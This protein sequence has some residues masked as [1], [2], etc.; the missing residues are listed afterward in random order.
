MSRTLKELIDGTRELRTLPSTTIRLLDLLD[1]ATAGAEAVLEVVEKDPSLTAN[2]LKLCNSAYYGLRAQ[3]GT[4]H[5]ALVRLGNLT[6][7]NLAF[8]ASMGDILRGPLAAYRLGRDQLWRHA[9]ATAAGAGFLAGSAGGRTLRERAFTGG[10][11]HD[12]GKLVANRP[13]REQLDQLPVGV[14]AGAMAAAEVRIL[15]F[16]HA[17]VGAA[18]ATAW[19]FPDTLVAV[20]GRHHLDDPAQ[21]PDGPLDT[22]TALLARAVAAANLI[23]AA[24]GY[25]GGS[26]GLEADALEEAV[27][28]LGFTSE[29][30]TAL[31]GRLDDDVSGLLGV[32]GSAR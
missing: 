5:E 13:L 2:L 23:A 30:L 9:L 21:A 26:A 4:A 17:A 10:L 1:D 7:V 32:F 24:A 31:Q 27:T 12:I 20:I 6:V 29:D 28:G 14:D 19:N 11:V 3:V 8:A 18:L 25:G 15:G 22:E 16:D